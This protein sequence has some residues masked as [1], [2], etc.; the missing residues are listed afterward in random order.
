MRR[1]APASPDCRARWRFARPL[2]PGEPAA[3]DPARDELVFYPLLYWP[4]VA[5][6]PLPSTETIEKI[7]AFMKGGGT[8]VFD[9]RDA[10]TAHPGGPPTPEG[11][12]LRKL[13]A[14]I[15]VPELEPVP[16]DH[17]VTKTFYLLDS[18]IG[19]SAIGQTWIEALPPEPADAAGAARPA[20]A[21]DSVSP[22]II[23]S[24]DLAAGW[25]GT[26]DGEP[27]YPLVP[28]GARQRELALRGGINLVMYTLTGNYKADQVHV[29][30]LLER[31]GQ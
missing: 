20:R 3:L 1:A 12:W 19:R 30:D 28:G 27:L 21:G 24:N 29:R 18:F 7:G 8:I 14:G 16:R 6:Q 9:T 17:V 10:L 23:T 26:S 2:V 11:A 25:A 4:I 13:L 5:S 22:I 31:L 15:D